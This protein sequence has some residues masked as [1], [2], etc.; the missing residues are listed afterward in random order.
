MPRLFTR[1]FRVRYG[2]CDAYGVLYNGAYLRYMLEA[3]FEASAAAGYDQAR[4]RQEG[5]KWLI[6][7]HQVEYLRPVV[8]GQTLHVQTWVSDIRRASSRRQYLFYR[9]P[10]GA[11]APPAEA[12]VMGEPGLPP[13]AAA[14]GAETI[15]RAFTDWL[16]LD[17]HSQQPVRVPPE[18]GAAFFPEGLP[19]GFAPRQPYLQAPPPPP[20]AFTT[21]RRVS[22]LDL[23]AEQHVN[24]A[25]Y[26]DYSNAAGFEA[27]EH[28]GWP[29]QR[30]RAE[31]FAIWMRRQQIQYHRPARLDDRL[32]INTWASEVRRSTATRHYLIH[33]SVAGGEAGELLAQVHSLGVWVDLATERPIR[34]PPRFLADFAPNIVEDSRA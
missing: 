33:R 7:A 19:S 17:A 4:Y 13:E 34:I 14:A 18:L 30:M 9:L 29:V 22:F 26:L 11:P 3:A 5:R 2:E 27:I 10:A 32:E 15:A 20:G 8:Y 23:D 1:P 24:N 25:V 16:Y 28:F 12:R 21:S 31:G 6:R